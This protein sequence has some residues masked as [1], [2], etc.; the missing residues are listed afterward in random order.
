V[1]EVAHLILKTNWPAESNDMDN[2]INLG[3]TSPQ[4]YTIKSG[5]LGKESKTE[6]GPFFLSSHSEVREVN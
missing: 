5:L 4:F 1:K 2:K 6:R 3:L